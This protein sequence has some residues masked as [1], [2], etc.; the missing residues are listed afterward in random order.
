MS[1][2]AV[3][4]DEVRHVT[5]ETWRQEVA[6]ALVDGFTWL[7]ALVG[8]DAIGAA[9]GPAGDDAADDPVPTIEVHLRLED[10]QGAGRRLV[11]A[12]PREN[13]VLP[14]L[15]DLIAGL[16]W[17]Q[18]E[19]HDEFGVRFE[20]DDLS[21]LLI[22]PGTTP[23]HPLRKDV[24]LAERAGTPWPGT[25]DTEPARRRSL[26][27]GVPDPELWRR[28]VSGQDV[29]ADEVVESLGLLGG[30]RGRGGRR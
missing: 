23:P 1:T 22:H 11:T 5:A 29:A 4:R 2:D 6:R 16:A 10:R 18:R 7:D 30:R 14:G 9:H 27:A 12:V 28:I 13:P 24:V 3:R 26:P 20:G 21:P 25:D 17:W 15:S 19:V 8:V